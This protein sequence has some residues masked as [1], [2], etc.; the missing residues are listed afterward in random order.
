VAK[1]IPFDPKKTPASLMPDMRGPELVVRM[2]VDV[3][4]VLDLVLE[5]DGIRRVYQLRPH[6]GRSEVVGLVGTVLASNDQRA[7]LYSQM[8]TAIEKDERE[9][10]RRV[11]GGDVPTA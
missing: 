4:P 11:D 6:D 3:E 2:S 5:R 8:L 7:W 10:W 1:R 9:G